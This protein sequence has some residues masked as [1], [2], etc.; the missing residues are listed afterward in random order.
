MYTINSLATHFTRRVAVAVDFIAIQMFLLHLTINAD[1][2][3]THDDDD[4]TL[5]TTRVDNRVIMRFFVIILYFID[6]FMCV[7]GDGRDEKRRE[8][9]K[10]AGKCKVHVS[11]LEET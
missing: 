1:L 4:E 11:M 2:N 5:E 10:C 8:D 9:E 7:M 3:S 6:S